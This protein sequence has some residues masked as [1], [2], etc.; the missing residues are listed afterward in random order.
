MPQKY[1]E[2][3]KKLVVHVDHVDSYTGMIKFNVSGK[4]LTYGL[5]RQVQ[6][7]VNA[8][9]DTS[10]EDGEEK[11]ED[12]DHWRL[13]KI[14]IRVSNGNVALDALKSDII[15]QREGGVRV[16]EDLEEMLDPFGDL[17]CGRE[18]TIGGAVTDQF[19]L[20]LAERMRSAKPARHKSESR[21]IDDRGFLPPIST[22]NVQVCVYGNDID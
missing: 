1:M 9:Q 10:R 21:R 20:N 7:L 2:L 3:V 18:V 15:R 8:L 11:E 5:K 19:A 4:G 17:H 22:G 16:A 6:R 13:S 14:N 12:R